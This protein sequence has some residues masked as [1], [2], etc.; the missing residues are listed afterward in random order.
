MSNLKVSTELF[1]ARFPMESIYLPNQLLGAAPV[2]GSGPP[3]GIA[4]N[5]P[6][7]HPSYC[8]LD[9]L[10]PWHE[11][12]GDCSGPW[13]TQGVS[14]FQSLRLVPHAGC[15]A[16]SEENVFAGRNERVDPCGAQLGCPH[17][18]TS[19]RPQIFSRWGS[20]RRSLR[21]ADVLP[22]WLVVSRAH[23]AISDLLPLHMSPAG[24]ASPAQSTNEVTAL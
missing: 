2:P 6:H 16:P 20:G 23:R 19:P 14:T 24:C 11:A 7:P 12:P 17:S 15:F 22:L 5:S 9:L 3:P 18:L 1:P 13:V 10:P 8:P 21:P 4:P